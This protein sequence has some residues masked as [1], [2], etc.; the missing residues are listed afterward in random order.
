MRC[1]ALAFI[2]A[3]IMLILNGC[4]VSSVS[5]YPHLGAYYTYDPYPYSGF[6]SYYGLGH[7]ST[8]EDGEGTAGEDMVGVDATGEDTGGKDIVGEDMAG[9]KTEG[10]VLGNSHVKALFDPLR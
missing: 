3:G 7:V 2:L 9:V 8:A 1:M 6:Y 5:P 4:A 10:F